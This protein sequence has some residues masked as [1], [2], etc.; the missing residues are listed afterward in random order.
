MNAK[1]VETG[2]RCMHSGQTPR[3]AKIRRLLVELGRTPT[4]NCETLPG[5]PQLAAAKDRWAILLLCCRDA[6]H[7]CRLPVD[8]DRAAWKRGGSVQDLRTGNRKSSL[9]RSGFSVMILRECEI[10][11]RNLKTRLKVFFRDH[12][13]QR[14]ERYSI[15]GKEYA[16]R[17]VTGPDRRKYRTIVPLARDASLT[18]AHAAFDHSWLRLPTAPS[19][20][21]GAA[22]RFVDLFCG[23]G[24]LSLGAREACAAMNRRFEPVAAI[25]MD[26]D[27]L[28]VYRANLSSTAAKRLDIRKIVNG[29]IGAPPT[30]SERKFLASISTVDFLLAGP[31]CQGHSN[32]NNHTRRS[33]SRNRL[34]ERV[35]RLAEIAA[36]AH[37]LIENVSTA[38]H[39]KEGSVKRTIRLL[40]QWGYHVSNAVVDLSTLGVPQRR[41]RHVVFASKSVDLDV[42]QL[43]RLF[44][45][46]HTRT[47][48]W[49][50]GDLGTQGAT[51]EFDRPAKLSTDNVVRI[52]HLFAKGLYDLPNSRRPECHRDED[53]SYKSMYGR[54]RAGEPAQTITSGFGSPG[55][56][57]YIHPARK[58]TLTPHEAARIQFFPDF[59][60]FDSVSRRLAL[61]QMIGNAVPPKLSYSIVLSALAL[62]THAPSMAGRKE[63]NA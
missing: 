35:A 9:E 12:E 16:Q 60:R 17:E 20:I 54:L 43:A 34:Y 11:R 19:A 36:P 46:K 56:G 21:K 10:E 29:E 1:L 51:I 45:L 3:L 30:N 5:R 25:D 53:H 44:P 55:Q 31:P 50:I 33:D 41:K 42:S 52:Q 26:E 24:G 4:A 37:I 23:C 28:K 32:L 57:R 61:S 48:G 49:A 2:G 59:F 8:R 38:M 6:R 63:V 47:V 58:R 27:A 7:H 18:D 13:A 62:E 40:K 14:L 15:V 39:G 22:V